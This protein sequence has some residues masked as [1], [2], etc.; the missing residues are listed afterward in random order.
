MTSND[1]HDFFQKGSNMML[2]IIRF[3]TKKSS[4]ST[5]NNRKALPK[6]LGVKKF[7]LEYVKPGEI[8]IT[9]RGNKWHCGDNTFQG[10]TFTIHSKVFGYAVFKK[11]FVHHYEAIQNNAP[12]E[13]RRKS[14]NDLIEITKE[15]MAMG[16]KIRHRFRE[17]NYI[18]VITPFTHPECFDAVPKHGDEDVFKYKPNPTLVA[19]MIPFSSL[20]D[21]KMTPFFE[22]KVPKYQLRLVNK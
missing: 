8:I 20:K 1:D 15:A 22:Y 14:E 17:R 12:F 2:T 3:A 5:Q 21:P 6:Y 19:S 18:H 11:D 9:Q 4:G 10:R 7:S 16:C 13:P